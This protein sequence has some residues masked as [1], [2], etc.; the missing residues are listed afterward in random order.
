MNSVFLH[1]AVTLEVLTMLL[2]FQT[3]QCSW[4]ITTVTEWA[5]TRQAMLCYLITGTT[6]KFEENK[7]QRLLT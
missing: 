4:D 6:V 1:N 5:G 3:S 7:T 2:N